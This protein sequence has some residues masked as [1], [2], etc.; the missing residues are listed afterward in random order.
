MYTCAC[1]THHYKWQRDFE[2]FINSRNYDDILFPL[3]RED[4]DC[5]R[6][7]SFT[8]LDNPYTSVVNGGSLLI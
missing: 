7:P 5:C 3:D 2:P 4:M 8:T 6:S 1:D